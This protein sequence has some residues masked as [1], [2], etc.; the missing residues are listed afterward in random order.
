MKLKKLLTTL[1]TLL[2]LTSC[3][4]GN[5]SDIPSSSTGVDIPNS[6]TSAVTPNSSTPA[7]GD[8]SSASSA[9]EE[10]S[11]S[12]VLVEDENRYTISA[13]KT[14]AEKGETV[15]I[16]VS[17]NAGFTIEKV[18][19][20]SD[21][22]SGTN[23]VYTFKMPSRD[24]RITVNVGIDGDLAIEGT[25]S[26]PL[27]EG[28][29]GIY[30]ATITAKEDGNYRY[31]VVKDGKETD[32]S[33]AN[34]DRT[35]CFAGLS[36]ASGGFSLPGGFTYEFYYNPAL[37]SRPCYVRRTAIDTNNLPQNADSLEDLFYGQ[38]QSSYSVYPSNVV[39]VHY[40][41]SYTA[42]TYDWKKYNDNSS[43]ATITYSDDSM[44]EDAIVYKS[45]D[46]EAGIYTVVDTYLESQNGL[47]VT[48][49][50][51]DTT[52]FA[53]K[54]MLADANPLTGTET[55]D[56]DINYDSSYMNANLAE[57]DAGLYS[58]SMQSIDF[59]IMYAYRTHVDVGAE[60][61]SS[62]VNISSVENSDGKGFTTTIKT[63]RTIDYSQDTLSGLTD[64]YHDDY[65]VTLVFDNAGALLS[66]SYTNRHYDEKSWDFTS[67]SKTGDGTVAKALTF[68]YEYGEAYDKLQ[69]ID[70]S[71]YFA[72]SVTATIANEKVTNPS[73]GDRI[74]TGDDL[75]EYLT[76]TAEPTTALDLWQYVPQSSDNEDVVAF[77]HSYNEWRG[78]SEGNAN[79]TISN[80]TSNDVKATV[81]L[82]VVY[83]GLVRSFWMWDNIDYNGLERSDYAY[84]YAGDEARY[85]LC[86]TADANSGITGEIPVPAD[87]YATFDDNG[88]VQNVSKDG[89]K[90]T[91][92][93]KTGVIL[94]D[95][96]DVTAAAFENGATYKDLSM[97]LH[98]SKYTE[99]SYYSVPTVITVRLYAPSIGIDTLVNGGKNWVDSDDNATLNFTLKDSASDLNNSNNARP[100]AGTL[101][102]GTTTYEF[103]YGFNQKTYDIYI[104]VR[105]ENLYAEA[106]YSDTTGSI[107][108]LLYSSVW[109]G[110]DETT[111]T[112]ILGVHGD[113][114]TEST[115][116]EFIAA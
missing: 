43:Y 42:E 46:K 112:D 114:D 28:E 52:K 86:A 31:K 79:I 71:A 57:F 59:D 103:A 102:I 85:T 110:L 55:D 58:H 109:G 94:F 21:E 100:Y 95:G 26:A 44:K 113:E 69:D 20:N 39:G 101:T 49:E 4:G 45:L 41:N 90:V 89:L 32:L 40:T 6:G 107:G 116:A 12:I 104:S 76:V 37:G 1:T 9:Q 13:D 53:G 82:D 84:A 73:T 63:S 83:A 17:A 51:G 16:T 70:V 60:V 106:F 99:V 67:D 72:T 81:S 25:Y 47:N 23:G 38:V 56:N 78:V 29:D 97:T 5:T 93:Y 80:G 77:N 27:V 22:I 3:G 50:L 19:V 35:R 54:Y 66:G 33:I 11:Y 98:T 68:S 87:T 88:D 18:M 65:D 48:A 105:G 115:Y 74:N 8:D 96:S 36:Y 91:I 24:V 64:K 75:E 111:D 92:N 62:D 15:T 2:V 30:K 34:F 10:T 14:K 7:G 61:V 108:F